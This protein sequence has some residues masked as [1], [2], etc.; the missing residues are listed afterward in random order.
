MGYLG[1]ILGRNIAMMLTLSTACF[2]GVCSATLPTGSP[3][4]VY[5]TIII[6]R[7]IL[8][9][10][11]GGVYPLSAAKAAEDGANEDHLENVRA[12]RQKS[13]HENNDPGDSAVTHG[14]NFNSSHKELLAGTLQSAMAFFWQVPG[15]M[16]PWALAYALS[17][18]SLTV[19]TTWRL[20]LGLG[21][22]PAALVVAL[23]IF[24]IKCNSYQMTVVCTTQELDTDSKRSRESAKDVKLAAIFHAA[25]RSKDIWFKVL[26]TG[27]GWFLYDV[28][29][30][31]SFHECFCNT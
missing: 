24:E 18:K 8:G 23:S 12:N 7:F 5:I 15:S 2:A 17:F 9:A 16:T 13:C 27:G 28:C 6:C 1:D 14:G 19:D 26:Y 11:L 22:I 21:S 10:G 25:F 20:L 30:C 3:T 31:K 29:F 4:S